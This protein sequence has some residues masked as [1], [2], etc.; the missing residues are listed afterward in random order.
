[1]RAIYG[2]PLSSADLSIW[3]A[4]HGG[5]KYDDLGNLVAVHDS[6]VPYVEGVEY[7]DITLIVGRRAAKSVISS[8][9]VAYEALCGGHKARLKIQDQQPYFLQVAQDL[10]RAMKNMREYILY[11]L[12][13]SPVGK[14]E[15]GDLQKSVTQRQIRLPNCGII[16]VGPPTVKLRGDSV[17]MCAMDEVA[18]WAKDEK[19]AAPDFEVERAVRSGMSQFYPYA[20]IL[21]TSTPWTE[22]GLL[23]EDF[24]VGTHGRFKRTPEERVGFEKK[25]VLKGPSPVL[26]NPTITREFLVQEK[27]KDA[28]AFRREILAEF[29]KSVSGFL[30]GPLVRRAV[31]EGTSRRPAV[32]GVWYTCAIDPAFRRDAFALAIGHLDASGS[33]VLDVC[34][35]W[36]G[37]P[38]QPLNP[39]IMLSIVG[40]IAREYGCTTVLSDQHHQDSLQVLAEQANFLIEP[41]TLTPK[42]KQAMWR[43]F[44]TLL[45]QDKVRLVANH[46]LVDELLMLE[47]TL[48][49]N[50]GE[51]IA[52]RRDDLAVV[53]AMCCHRALSFGVT[54][55]EVVKKPVT[56][57]DWSA[58]AAKRIEAGLTT[59]DRSKRRE[60]WLR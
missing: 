7:Q 6:G 21:K 42:T 54:A 44:V 28:D 10:G 4:L 11:Y 3:H 57:E 58:F 48:T 36:R 60:W 47:K 53:T 16:Q 24:Q 31:D 15:L 27:A 39:A 55:P 50:G 5:G 29:A 20:K 26:R 56:A 30:P 51:R 35:S 45:N 13:S 23:W 41:F 38:D 2:L 33:F 14:V 34:Q 52:G 40:P 19:S 43:D 12:K 9:I 37:T 32:P 25:L 59:P 8:F 1:M 18:F 49:P 46:E 22:D 17:A